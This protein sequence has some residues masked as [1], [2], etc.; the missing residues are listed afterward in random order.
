MFANIFKSAK[1]Q[2]IE[3]ASAIYYEAWR[4]NTNITVVKESFHNDTFRL[5][6]GCLQVHINSFIF[7]RLV[8]MSQYEKRITTNNSEILKYWAV[9]LA[10]SNQG[11][12]VSDFL[13]LVKVVDLT[14]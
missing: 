10:A 1:K 9:A 2:V 5:S 12:K 13:D 14:R 11:R 8:P 7:G 4:T 3:E 6:C